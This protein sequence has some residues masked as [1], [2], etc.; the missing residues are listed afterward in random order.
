M[1]PLCTVVVLVLTAVTLALAGTTGKI[2]GEVKDSQTGEPVIGAN[3]TVEGTTL[4]AATNIDGYFVILNLP[5]GK[6]NVVA[7]AVG[8]HKRT[9][10]GVI[11][12]VDL[13]TKVDF[14][15]VQTV[16]ESSEELVITA[17]RP[18]IKRDLTS[19]EAR[20]DASAIETIPVNEVSEVLSLQAG[21][22]TDKGGGIH[23]R[24]GRTNEVAYWVDGV[25]ISDGFD[26]SQAVQVDNGSIQELQVI[27]GT[28]N[29]EYGQAMSG[30]VNIVTK[31]GGQ[32]SS[33]E[34]T[35]HQ[36]LVTRSTT[37]STRFVR[38]QTRT[39]KA[40]SVVQSPEHH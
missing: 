35:H 25:S 37:T 18:V 3:V 6:Y 38:C 23:I 11:V 24:G 5:P 31:D 1:K 22:T 15:L 17:E 8:Y 9:Y 32:A 30:I 40:A 14:K 29:A 34:A 2:T 20:V 7:S 28:F 4:G 27:S 13:T 33:M 21:I 36:C 10:G 39:W 26:H 16:L 12:S 19:S